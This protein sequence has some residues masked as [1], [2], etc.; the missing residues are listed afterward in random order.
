MSEREKGH[1]NSRRTFLFGLLTGAGVA[2]A[3]TAA[4]LPRPPEA[5]KAAAGG[6]ASRSE[7]I[8]YQRTPEAERYYK[9]LYL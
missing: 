1:G 9:T 2:A 4:A 8:L 3:V 5:K 6:P 7:P